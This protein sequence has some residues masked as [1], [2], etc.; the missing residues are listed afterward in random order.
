M[1]ERNFS[2]SKIDSILR[3][4]QGVPDEDAPD[5]VESVRFWCTTGSRYTDKEKMKLEMTASA[6]VKT[7]PD[8][9]GSLLGENSSA[10][11]LAL[12]NGASPSAGPSHS[13]ESLLSCANQSLAPGGAGAKAKCKAKAKA[14]AK[15]MP[16]SQTEKTPAEKREAARQQLKKEL[17]ACSIGMELPPNHA[18]RNQLGDQKTEFEKLFEELRTC[19]DDTLPSVLETCAEQVSACRFVRAQARAVVQEYKKAA[20]ADGS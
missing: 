14:K 10:A 5:D 17:T 3:K 11:P 19:D 6:T 16:G 13:L 20:Q 9:M 18:L 2:Q 15:S 8:A 7:T 4:Q 12:T 1:R